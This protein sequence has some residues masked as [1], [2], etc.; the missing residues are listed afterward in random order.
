MDAVLG[1]FDFITVNLGSIVTAAFAVIGVLSHAAAA[2]NLTGLAKISEKLHDIV[3]VAA[4]N[5]GRA[6]N[7][8]K[9]VKAY[10]AD[11]PLAALNQIEV[12][13]KSDRLKGV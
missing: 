6:A 2:F 13:V 4:G 11:G 1:V 9:V 5:W 7:V 12:L 10:R 3:Q 8:V